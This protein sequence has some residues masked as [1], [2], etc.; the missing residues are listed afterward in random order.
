MLTWTIGDVRIT[1]VVEMAIPF[2]ATVLFPAATPDAIAAVPWLTPHWINEEG[3]LTL[4]V[5]ALVIEA[6]GRRIVVDTCM[7]NDKPR[8][9][10]GMFK[11]D[12]LERFEEAGF[13]R[14]SIDT[15]LCTHLHLDHV[16][17]NTML[18][19]GKWIPTFPNARYLIGRAE[20]EYWRG[21]TDGDDAA[22]FSDSV[23]PVFD[24]GLMDL[25]ATD[26]VICPEVRLIPTHGHTPGHVSVRISSQGQN[27]LIT[28]D[29]THHPAQ[30]A[31][32]DWGSFVDYDV[33]TSTATRR[34]MMGEL[35]GQ[36]V[37]VIGTH[38]VAPTA[39]HVVRDGDAFRFEA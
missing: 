3:F 22:I 24:A 29:M 13:A 35:A 21:Q 23:Q 18:V 37:L 20:F 31:R 27:A 15:V 36:P 26:H 30:F 12:F 7:G 32:P 2:P 1:C 19:D 25:V 39:G 34:R 14:D 28:G 5:Q 10:A 6:P 38:F 8:T 17:W 9:G 33:E 11:T 16:G 4:S